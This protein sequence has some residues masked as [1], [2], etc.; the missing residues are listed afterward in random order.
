MHVDASHQDPYPLPPDAFADWEPA[1]AKAAVRAFLAV[2]GG[3]PGH[4][5]EDLLHEALVAWW[6]ERQGYDVSRAA[7]PKTYLNRV[8]RATLIDLQRF[9][10][11][12]KR[13]RGVR[14]QSLDA[15]LDVDDPDG[16]TLLDELPGTIAGTDPESALDLSRLREAIAVAKE[17]LGL[18]PEEHRILDLRLTGHSPT[19]IERL[20]GIRRTTVNSRLEKM[21]LRLRSPELAELLR[22][23]LD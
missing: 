16:D 20:T 6:K 23:F 9:A 3:L 2:N 10:L 12:Q 1:A 17:R 21:F 13:G 15:P 22:H 19:E 8:V 14:P 4:E 7:N 18:N 5:F 11:A